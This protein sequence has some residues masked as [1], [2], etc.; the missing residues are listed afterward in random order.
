MLASCCI[1]AV[2]EESCLETKCWGGRVQ[3]HGTVPA[4]I[5]CLDCDN[6]AA[7]C[8]ELVRLHWVEKELGHASPTILALR[9]LYISLQQP[10]AQGYHASLNQLDLRLLKVL[11]PMHILYFWRTAGNIRPGQPW[12]AVIAVDEVC[13]CVPCPHAVQPQQPCGRTS[14]MKRRHHK[15]CPYIQPQCVEC[16][17]Q[18]CLCVQL[19]LGKGC[20]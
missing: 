16:S 3:C 5:H 12:M 15:S 19:S 18:C 10:P 13:V 17:R 14:C 9:M 2:G 6:L 7:C 8:V 1:I 4:V 11:T 20:C